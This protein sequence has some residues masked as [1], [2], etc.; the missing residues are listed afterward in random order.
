MFSRVASVKKQQKRQKGQKEYVGQQM[1]ITLV[2]CRQDSNLRG[3]T[4][5]DF[6]S[7][8]LTTRPRQRNCHRDSTTLSG[9]ITI[10]KQVLCA[11][12]HDGFEKVGDDSRKYNSEAAEDVDLL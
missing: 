10:I 11:K 2:R 12:E 7:T 1:I 9:K 6:E 3:G 4:P 5:V 8:A